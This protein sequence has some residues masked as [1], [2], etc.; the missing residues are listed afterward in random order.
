MLLVA[1]ATDNEIKP[2]RQF[3][4]SLENLAVLVT[5]MGPAAAAAKLSNYLTLYGSKVSGVINIGIGGA[6]IGS[7]LGLLDICI[8]R[9]E[10]FGDFG[11][12]MQ[13]GIHDFGPGLSQLNEPYELNN[14]LIAISGNLL[15]A[16]GFD[17][18]VANF[19]TVNCCSGTRKRGDYLKE[20]FSAGCENM[21]GAAVVMVCETFN[22]PC[23]EMRCISNMVE[24]RNTENWKLEDAIGEI[25]RAAEAILQDIAAELQ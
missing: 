4:S 25:S 13:D 24:D 12:C 17:F 21:E 2:L 20:K 10:V 5:G 9:Q 1:A 8:A 22:I 7:G 3:I 19:V 11:I 6:Y 16:K 18:R 15:K 14:K 23:L